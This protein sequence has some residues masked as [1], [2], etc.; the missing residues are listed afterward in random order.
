L[1]IGSQSLRGT[2]DL[3]GLD[4]LTIVNAHNN[5]LTGVNVTGLTNLTLLDVRQNNLRSTAVIVGLLPAT[6]TQLFFDPQRTTTTRP[7]VDTF[8]PTPS[9]AP[10][11]TPTPTPGPAT[12]ASVGDVVVPLRRVGT[13][14]L[15]NLPTTR[16]AEI[17]RNTSDGDTVTFDVTELQGHA[18]FRYVRIQSSAFLAFGQ[19]G[20]TIEFQLPNATLLIDPAAAISIAEQS[21]GAHVWVSM[22]RVTASELSPEQREALAP[23][24]LV[25]RV[26][27]RYLF[28]RQ[29]IE[30]GN[31]RL[32][33]V[34]PNAA[35][36]QIQNLRQ[37]VIVTPNA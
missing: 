22:Q 11:A 28:R 16:T 19:A 25:Y 15:L 20:L 23:G 9:P 31:G 36:V 2:L 29:I 6:Q 37:Y 32:T 3:T 4:A 8:V 18:A 24:Q 10:T 21:L 5:Y 33:L 34:L 13:Q 35:N 27:V 30:F 14:I 1:N 12:S 26:E 17:I 7:P